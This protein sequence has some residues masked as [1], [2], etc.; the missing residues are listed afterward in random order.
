VVGR[1]AVVADCRAAMVGGGDATA[2]EEGR[3]W[4]DN[5]W[6]GNRTGEIGSDVISNGGGGGGARGGGGRLPR[7]AKCDE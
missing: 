2:S 5:R 7:F 4:L 6:V 3:G 1:L